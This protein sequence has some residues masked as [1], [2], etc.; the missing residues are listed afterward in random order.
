MTDTMFRDKLWHTVLFNTF[1]LM[2]IGLLTSAIVATSVTIFP[3]LSFVYTNIFACIGFMISTFALVIF[4][5][6]FSG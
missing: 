3:Q 6:L 4:F 5:Y 2:I 1:A